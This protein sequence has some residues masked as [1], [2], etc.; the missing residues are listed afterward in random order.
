MGNV[1]LDF[2][3]DVNI[4]PKKTWE[5]MVEPTLGYSNI[6]LNLE[7]QKRVIPIGRLKNTTMDLDGVRTTTNFKVMDMVDESIPFPTLLA[8]DWAFENHTIYNLKTRKMIFE[9]DNFRVVSPLYPSYY[10]IYVE[11]APNIVLGDDVNHLYRITAREENHV[12]PT[13]YGV[14]SWRSIN[15]DMSDLDNGVENWQQILHE[16]SNRRCARITHTVRWVGIEVRHFPIFTEEEN[17]ENF[18]RE[19]ESEVLDSQTLLVLDIPL[20]DKHA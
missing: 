11:L 2:V 6:K 10:D 16:V 1:I 17:L 5:A 18:L 9:D 3:S 8:I 14:L 4:F 20:R 13:T 7:N 19:F 12:S 15:S